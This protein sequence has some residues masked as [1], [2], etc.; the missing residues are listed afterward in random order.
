LSGGASAPNLTEA[1][2]R[3]IWAAMLSGPQNMPVFG[4]NQLTP[5]EKA[6]VI[7]YIN[8]LAE[9]GDPGGLFN[10]GRLGPAT[11]GLAIFLVGIV[12]VVFATL[13]IAGKS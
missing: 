5:Q 9:D 10:L 1:T 13:W 6:D 7:A 3:Q 4:D 2:D 12:A 11:E 8:H